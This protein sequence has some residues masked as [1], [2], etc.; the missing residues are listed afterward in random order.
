MR[1]QAVNL[2]ALVPSVPSSILSRDLLQI[3]PFY[4]LQTK[5]KKDGKFGI[6]SSQT[7]SKQKFPLPLVILKFTDF[8]GTVTFV[9]L[10][11][12]FL[13]VTVPNKSPFSGHRAMPW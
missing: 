5:K 8:L 3:F 4:H 12:V 1:I 10:E 11:D 13:N 9:S 7:F 2:S 6:L